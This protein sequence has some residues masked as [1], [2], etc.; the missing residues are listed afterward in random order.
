[1]TESKNP[2]ISGS[3]PPLLKS[4]TA[5]KYSRGGGLGGET[6]DSRFRGNDKLEEEGFNRSLDCARDDKN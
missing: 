6:L 3:D 5:G 4:T 1:M 2:G